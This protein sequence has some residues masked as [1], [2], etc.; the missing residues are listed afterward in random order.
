MTAEPP[1]EGLVELRGASVRYADGTEVRLVDL[2]LNPGDEVALVGPS[3]SGKTT[4][5]HVLAGLVKPTSG[6]ARVAETDLTRVGTARLEL[7][8]A[9]TV[10]LMFQDFHLLQGFSALEQ[11]TAAL[12]LAGIPIPEAT[13]RARALLERVQLGHRLHATPRKLS[14]G[15]RQRVAL[16]RA[17][18]AKPKLL[19]V[20]EPTA[21]LDPRRGQVALELLRELT[22]EVGAALLIATHDPVV[23]AALPRQVATGAGDPSADPTLQNAVLT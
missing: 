8:R 17:L 6:L 5:L 14:T 7:Y 22:R 10:A 20:D 3:G 2:T 11:V 15:E 23:I 19:L 1:A 16:A 13:S 18:A 4:L 12:G 9:R 21:H